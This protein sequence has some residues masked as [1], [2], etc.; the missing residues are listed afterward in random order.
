MTPSWRLQ[1]SSIPSSLFK[2]R[3]LRASFPPCSA[4]PDLPCPAS[5]ILVCLSILER[6]YPSIPGWLSV[7][8][9]PYTPALPALG[10]LGRGHHQS[11]RQHICLWTSSATLAPPPGS[12]PYDIISSLSYSHPSQPGPSLDCMLECDFRSFPNAWWCVI[13]SASFKLGSL[14]LFVC[15]FLSF[16]LF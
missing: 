9:L 14:C 16:C 7:S 8:A 5:C 15:F 4:T 3:L 13:S 10:W 2:R 1:P 11:S 12:G 6:P